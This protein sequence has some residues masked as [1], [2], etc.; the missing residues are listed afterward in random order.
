MARTA[1]MPSLRLASMLLGALGSWRCT[2]VPHGRAAVAKVEIR[3]ASALSASEVERSIATRESPRFL[4]LFPEFIYEPEIFN[5]HL[6]DADLERIERFYDARGHH[7]A[8]VRQGLMRYTD[9]SHVHVLIEVQEGAPTHVRRLRVSGLEAIP[10]EVAEAVRAALDEHLRQGQRFEE[11][12]YEEAEGAMQRTLTDRGYARAQVGRRARVDVRGYFADVSYDVRPGALARLGEVHLRGLGTLPEAPLRR[13]LDLEPGESYSTA[14]LEQAQQAALELGVFSAVSVRPRLDATSAEPTVVP[15]DVELSGT[16]LETVRLGVGLQLDTLQTGAHVL[17]GYE[18]HNFLGGLRR[19]SLEVRPGGVFYPTRVDNLTFPDHLLPELGALAT[20]R[21]PGFLEA[22]TLGSLRVQYNV[23]AVL[24]ALS[25]GA[26][27]LGYREA[28]IVGALDRPFGRHLR[29]QPSYNVQTNSPFAYVGELGEGLTRLVISY[30][31]L[32]LSLDFRDRILSPHQGLQALVPVQVAGP[33]GDAADL[34]VKPELNV[35]VPLAE[36]WTF[37]VSGS[38]GFLFPFNYTG[39][40]TSGRDAQLLFFRG[41]FAG[42]P[43]SNRGYPQRGIGPHGALPFLYVDGINPCEEANTDSGE[44]SVALG[45]LSIWEASA[46][47]RYSLGGPLNLAVFCDAAD[48]NR[49]RFELSLAR[50]HLS[51]G[52]GLR[53]ETPV[54]PLRADVGVRIPGLQVISGSADEPAP[55]QIFGLP[56]AFTI[57]IGQAF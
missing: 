20:L 23:Y 12:P 9:P 35:F 57:G 51:C 19:L 11:Q 40:E 31:E 25:D 1:R 38:V 2:A 32:L 18:H 53:Y 43:A 34:R 24:N 29:L 13:A 5:R 44:C 26:D 42:G 36:D 27:V 33:F 49:R 17:A 3:G 55:S 8:M 52:P 30:S 28:K 50:P 37:A 39:P 47:F 56:I 7:S 10:H 54:G 21:Q 22:R 15:I 41:F 14:E 45:G 46:E 16:A 4:G 48:V 6:L